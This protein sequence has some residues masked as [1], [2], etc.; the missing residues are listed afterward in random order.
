[1]R[2]QPIGL[3]PAEVNKNAETSDDEIEVPVFRKPTTVS[4]S[5]VEM[6]D[7][8][9]PVSTS[10]SKKEKSSKRV[11]KELSNSSLKRKHTD[12]KEKKSKSS[13]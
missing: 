4:D 13:V 9:Q 7:V 11:E 12:G 10:K 6:M 1:M 2:F 5:D 3:G 8:P